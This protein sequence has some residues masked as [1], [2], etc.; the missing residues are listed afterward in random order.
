MFVFGLP[1]VITGRPEVVEEIVNPAE[2][3]ASVVVGA[4]AGKNTAKYN[5]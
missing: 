5:V 4:D 1:L 3:C 2:V